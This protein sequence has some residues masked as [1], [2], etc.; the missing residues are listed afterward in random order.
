MFEENVKLGRLELRNFGHRIDLRR[1]FIASMTANTLPLATHSSRYC[2]A[3]LSVGELA[4]NTTAEYRGVMWSN[5]SVTQSQQQ[6]MLN[7]QQKIVHNFNRQ[8]VAHRKPFELEETLANTKR[9]S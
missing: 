7:S 5:E 1:F 2:E 3:Q 9:K 8:F 4:I 6:F